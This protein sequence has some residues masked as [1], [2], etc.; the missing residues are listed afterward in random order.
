MNDFIYS[1]PTKQYFGKTLR[2]EHL[3]LS[4]QIRQEGEICPTRNFIT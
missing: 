4:L 3:M 1:Y 2:K